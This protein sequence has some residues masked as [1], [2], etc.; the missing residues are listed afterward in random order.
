M[1]TPP[2]LRSRFFSLIG[3]AALLSLAPHPADAA[4]VL[5]NTAPDAASILVGNSAPAGS[6]SIQYSRGAKTDQYGGVAFELSTAAE[7]NAVT[8]FLHGFGNGAS[9]AEVSFSIVRF[10]AL[11]AVP[12]PNPTTVPAYPY[13]FE[14]TEVMSLPTLSGGVDEGKYITFSLETPVSLSAGTYGVI[15]QFAGPAGSQSIN[16]RSTSGENPLA[17]TLRTTDTWV[18][19]VITTSTYSVSP[20]ESYFAVTGTAAVPEPSVAWLCGAGLLLGCRAAWK[21]RAPAQVRR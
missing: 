6:G 17:V 18:D 20:T 4:V 12:S 5:S 10:A 2:L 21:R 1:K 15:F 14:Y 13:T 11:P 8:F 9:K 16:F 7:I 19:G 3:A